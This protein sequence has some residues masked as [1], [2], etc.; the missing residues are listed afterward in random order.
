MSLVELDP[1][2]PEGFPIDNLPDG[3]LQLETPQETDFWLE[4]ALFIPVTYPQTDPRPR[5]D[6]AHDDK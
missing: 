2:L 1:G 6:D 4:A 5:H 3:E